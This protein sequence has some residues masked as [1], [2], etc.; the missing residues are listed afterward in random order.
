[1]TTQPCLKKY[2]STSLKILRFSNTSHEVEAILR[3]QV[4]LSFRSPVEVWVGS[5]P[6]LIP[7]ARSFKTEVQVLMF[8]HMASLLN[9]HTGTI[10][11]L[12]K[13]QATLDGQQ[14]LT[15]TTRE[16]VVCSM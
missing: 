15:V 9:P 12:S 2:L 13:L 10:S 8:F 1:M 6:F 16:I 14:Q 5:L 3:T 7:K 11:C 4:E